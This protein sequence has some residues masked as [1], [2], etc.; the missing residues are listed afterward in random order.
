M[1]GGGVF[2]STDYG[3]TWAAANTGLTNLRVYALAINS[4]IPA[5]LYAGTDAG[6]VF[7]SSDSGTTWAAA[8]TGV[9]KLKVYALALDPT[10]ATTLYAG[11]EYGSVW[12][13][14]PSTL[15]PPPAISGIMPEYGTTAGGTA[16]TITGTN[17]VSGASVTIGGTAATS[18]TVVSPTQ[19]AATTPAHV[20]GAVNVVVT[21]ADAQ[22]ATAAGG[23]TYVVFGSPSSFSATAT[24]TSQVALS[25]S[26]VVGATSYEVWRSLLNG[27]YTLAATTAGTSANDAER[28]ANT[29][30]LYKV[31]AIGSSGPSAF[32]AIDPATTM[33]FTDTS[34][35]GVRITIAHI[36]EL[37]TAV[38]AMR[39]AAGLA[40][41]TFTDPTLTAGGTTIK[42][43]HVTELR[44]A[45]DAARSALLLP[46]ISYTDSTITAGVTAM[47]SAHLTELR[48]GTQ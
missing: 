36:A 31:R 43:L 37:R 10:G 27:P 21:N 24:S 9:P 22:S 47:K 32:T 18:I 19:I 45:L 8:N 28:N 23:Y 2:R 48:A 1:H 4:S 16:V 39:A 12:Q 17:F 14:S 7:K 6:G 42:R 11:L 33:V 41:A 20:A 46:A 3:N 38:N 13:M 25:W 26:D 34:L 5:T 40:A 15:S 44:T 35:S 30:Y 29:T